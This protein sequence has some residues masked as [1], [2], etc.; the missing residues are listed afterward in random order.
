[1]SRRGRASVE[2]VAVPTSPE[3]SSSS[4]GA[5]G[6]GRDG[7]GVAPEAALRHSLGRERGGQS[8]D[9]AQGK[10][11]YGCQGK[12]RQGQHQV[13][14]Q[15][16]GEAG[17]DRVGGGV[18]RGGHDS[19]LRPGLQH[20][21]DLARPPGGAQ[22]EAI[23]VDASGQECDGVSGNRWKRHPRW[24]AMMFRREAAAIWG[25]LGAATRTLSGPRGPPLMK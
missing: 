22:V 6:L 11:P 9:A 4:G 25:H 10:E 17:C 13:S 18:P 20:V 3:S 21:L 24:L 8:Q 5:G 1:M 14:V 2:T 15:E 19:Q 16:G 12:D 23:D 7:G